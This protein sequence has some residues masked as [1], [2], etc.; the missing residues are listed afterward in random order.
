[1]EKTT[2]IYNSLLK[3]LDTADTILKKVELHVTEGKA[4]EAEV[5]DWKL[6]DDM[7]PF[8]RQ[9]QILTD[10]VKGALCRI[11][12]T[13]NPKFEDNEKTIAELF[14]RIEKTRTFTKTIDVNKIGKINSHINEINNANGADAVDAMTI[15][16]PWMP[17][18]M[19]WTGKQYTEG[20]ILQNCYFHLIT[21]YGIVRSKGVQIGKMDFI[22]NI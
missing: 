16:L 7:L 19:S 11:T 21:A 18:G 4:T 22:G 20:F 17:E 12:N 6:I 10:N 15:K 9:I 14:T 5:M 1:M 8:V 13:E 2:F 3:I